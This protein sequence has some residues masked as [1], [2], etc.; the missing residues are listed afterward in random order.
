[1]PYK[2]PLPQYLNSRNRRKTEPNI[3]TLK[4]MRSIKLH[5]LCSLKQSETSQLNWL[6]T[7]SSTNDSSSFQSTPD[8]IKA[9]S[10]SDGK[11][12]TFQR[13]SESEG[14]SPTSS[15]YGSAATLNQNRGINGGNERMRISKLNKHACPSCFRP[16]GRRPKSRLNNPSIELPNEVESET[17]PSHSAGLKMQIQ[18]SPHHSDS[19]S[20]HSRTSSHYSKS[21]SAASSHKSLQTLTKSSSMRS[22]RKLRT[23]I[24]FKS[25]SPSVKKSS[26][27]SQDLSLNRATCS[28][29]LK[30][31]KFPKQAEL[32]PG[33]SESEIISVKKVCPYNHCS[34]HGHSHAPEPQPKRFLYKRRNSIKTQKGVKPKSLSTDGVAS[35]GDKKKA[36]HKSKMVSNVEPALAKNN[37]STGSS[38]VKNDQGF[39]FTKKNIVKP[40]DESYRGASQENEEA[41]VAGILLGEKSHPAESA[42]ENLNQIQKFHV[43]EKDILEPVLTEVKE[44]SYCCRVESKQDESISEVKNVHLKGEE[45]FASNSGN[46]INFATFTGLI[47][48]EPS[49]LIQEVS[50]SEDSGET[51]KQNNEISLTS[52]HP[53][54]E[55]GASREE[56]NGNPDPNGAIISGSTLARECETNGFIPLKNDKARS[57]I[58]EARKPRVKKNNHISMWHMI[59]QQMVLGLAEEAENQQFQPTDEEGRVDDANTLPETNSTCLSPDITN[60]EMGTESPVPV[61]QELELRKVFAIKLVREAIE[62]ILLP[63]VEDQSSDMISMTSEAISDEELSEKNQ[64]K[65]EEQSISNSKVFAEQNFRGTDNKELVGD[66][67]VDAEKVSQAENT[68]SV[69]EEESE[70]KKSDKQTLKGWSNLR[71]I[72]LLKRFVKELEKVKKFNPAK[73]QHQPLVLESEAEKVSLRPQMMGEKKNAEEWMLDYALRQVVSQL[74]PTQKRKVALL[75]KA[76][77]TVVPPQ[78]SVSEARDTDQKI[79]DFAASNPASF[80][81]SDVSDLNTPT[82]KGSQLRSNAS[83]KSDDTV[84]YLHEKVSVD[85][86]DQEIKGMISNLNYESGVPELIDKFMELDKSSDVAGE[87]PCAVNRSATERNT[88][89]NAAEIVLPTSNS[90]PLEKVIPGKEETNRESGPEHVVHREFPLLVS[91]KPD[92]MANRE[93]KTQ[94]DK[95]NIKMWHMIYQHVVSGIAAK[96]GSQLLDGADEEQVDDANMSP[97]RKSFGSF[98]E[99]MKTDHDAGKENHDTNHQK[100]EFSKSIAVKLVQEAVDEIL[101]PEIQDDSSD[102]QSVAS[103]ILPDQELIEKHNGDCGESSVLNSTD[104]DDDSFKE[105]DKSKVEDGVSLYQEKGASPVGNISTKEDKRAASMVANRLEQQKSKNWSKLKKLILLKRSI[106]ALENVRKLN[107]RPPQQ[108]PQTRDPEEEKIDLRRQMMDERKKAEQWMLDYAVQHIVTK[109]TP[110]RKRRVAMLVEAFEAVVPLPEV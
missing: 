54:E 66:K 16:F 85:L 42:N 73:P 103:D 90:D 106:K 81:K 9:I 58:H 49:T 18:A 71:K 67:S 92:S 37:Y 108:V 60:S 76:F 20:D 19:S 53:L 2:S 102:S 51:T 12:E 70:R 14:T 89:E 4:K 44:T 29:T 57:T 47:K 75:V 110:A 65:S 104:S 21:N 84:S 17:S 80:G 88:E 3:I 86:K 56:K 11:K 95:Q 93:H 87:P 50:S 40:R 52:C 64:E 62:K 96:V 63:E 22:V 55:L 41:D 43:V 100:I 83:L 77:E 91:F 38:L 6:S 7:D 30:D 28:S 109:L 94:L 107:S 101:L 34:L 33:Q 23:K 8:R 5:K 105:S 78:E 69:P 82:L 26:Q 31:S 10:F 72:I 97:E 25:K 45:V 61:S 99:N 39:D 32:Y 59:H 13:E 35:S 68:I 27:I 98:H 46:G 24:S 79:E 74:A 48:D 1:M 36:F 15:F